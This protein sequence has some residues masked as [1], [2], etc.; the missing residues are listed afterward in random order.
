MV[1][2]NQVAKSSAKKQLRIQI[3]RGRVR[4]QS[5]EDSRVARVRVPPGG[6]Y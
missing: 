1:G 4:E 3:N 6:K 5:P 2:P